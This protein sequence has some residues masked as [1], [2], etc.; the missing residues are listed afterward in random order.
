MP[1]I[2]DTD[3]SEAINLPDLVDYLNEAKIDTCDND[4]MLSVGFMLKRLSNN[5]T[6]ISDLALEELK[7]RQNLGAGTNRYGPQVIMLYSP[8]KQ[9]QNFFLRANFWP[10]ANDHIYLSSGPEQF[11]Y[12]HPHDHSFNFLTVGHFGPGYSSNYYTY[13]YENVDGYPGE[14]AGLKYVETMALDEGKVMLYRAC[15]DIHDQLPPESMS[16]SLNIMEL[17]PRGGV[18]DQYSFDTGSGTVT[19]MIN[20]MSM[21]SLMPLVAAAGGE[22]ATDYLVNT[23]KSHNVG[24]V[25]VAALRAMAAHA[26][27][28]DACMQ[29]LR[30][31]TSNDSSMV[32]GW[33]RQELHRVEQLAVPA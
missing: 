6:F 20:R 26:T 21:A 16:I 14:V 10:A 8:Q 30:A 22:N 27:S 15:V 31:G 12:H 19:N 28:R 7:T 29:I 33:A 13:D 23:L 24:R 2:I 32:A 25:R 18:C 3:E 4:S 17:S 11:F 9:R 5:R 1:V